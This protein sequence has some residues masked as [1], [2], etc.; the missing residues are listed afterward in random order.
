MM[1]ITSKMPRQL[2][3]ICTAWSRQ[4][5]ASAD[6]KHRQRF[7]RDHLPSLLLNR[8]LFAGLID[9]IVRGE[10]YPDCRHTDAFDNEILLYL[11]P[12]RIFS[13]RM[14]LFSPGE[15]TP[16][17]DHNSWGVTGAVWGGLT[18]IRYRREDDG[19]IDGYARIRET[20]RVTLA[21]GEIEFTLPLD[22][23][24]HETGTATEAPMV[25]VSVYGNPVRRLYVNRFD[26]DKNRVDKLYAPR[27]KKKRLAQSIQR[28]VGAFPSK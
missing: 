3:E 24:I 26:A 9:R 14:F 6:P 18:V 5:E 13:L 4:M 12:K 1:P 16:I 19:S 15:F 25:M 11:N 2:H 27:M 28:I 23:G 10:T 7:I 20:D 8:S 21:P 17:H 22:V